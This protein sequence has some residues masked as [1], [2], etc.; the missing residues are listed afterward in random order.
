MTIARYYVAENNPEGRS[1][2]GVPLDDISQERWES[3]PDHLRD[4]VDASDMYRKTKPPSVK[5]TKPPSEPEAAPEMSA[6]VAPEQGVS[7]G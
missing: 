6:D 1:F 2:P 3:I 5:K 4:S 7:N